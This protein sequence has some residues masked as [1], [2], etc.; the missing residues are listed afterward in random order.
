[1]RCGNRAGSWRNRPTRRRQGG[2][3][4]PGGV[5]EVSTRPPS[6][7]WPRRGGT[8][9]AI[10]SSTVVLPAPDGPNSASRSPAATLSAALTLNSRRS[11]STSASSTGA[12]D[13][14]GKRQRQRDHQQDQ[15]EWQRG[16]QPGLLQGRPDLQRDAV[17]MVGHDDHGTERSHGA[18]PGHGQRHG[19]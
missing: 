3:K 7:T 8:R 1:D 5:V 10:A 19:Q 14:G 6:V 2:T 4:Q 17:R 18:G 16:G 9:P 15:G 11:T 13:V 12:P